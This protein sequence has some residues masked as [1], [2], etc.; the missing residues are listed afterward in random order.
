MEDL[1]RRQLLVAASATS[2]I[3]A[4]AAAPDIVSAGTTGMNGGGPV[5]PPT[6][7][8]YRFPLAT[9]TPQIRS[10]GRHDHEGGAE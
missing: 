9:T 4:I 7:D 6:P 8:T 3:A 2:A 1:S 5:L 10:A